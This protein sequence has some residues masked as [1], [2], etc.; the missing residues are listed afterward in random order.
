MKI[1]VIYPEYKEAVTGGQIYDHYFINRIAEKEE[2]QVDF[3]TDDMLFTNSK[4][5]YNFAYLQKLSHIKKYDVI[6]TNSR[7]YTRLL[8]PFF[9]LRLFGKKTKRINI[10][11][12]FDFLGARRIPPQ[13]G[14]ERPAG[15]L[16]GAPYG[17]HRRR[18]A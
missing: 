18:V 10:H 13:E 6:L 12:H 2:H 4:Y 8:L 5:L 16:R 11:H 17:S 3:L 14:R 15:T 9:A 7:L 1:L